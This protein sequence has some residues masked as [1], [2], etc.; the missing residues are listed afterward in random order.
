M[1]VD[2]IKEHYGTTHVDYVV[3][4]H[5]DA[6]HASGLEVVLEELTV[7]EVWV[8]CPWEYAQ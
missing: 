2:H 4:A 7:G 3:S 5:P 8:H 1:L 6:D